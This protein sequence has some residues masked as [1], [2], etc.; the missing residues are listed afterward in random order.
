MSKAIVSFSGGQDST[1]CLFWALENFDEVE[2]IGFYY[3]QRHS[4]ELACRK[5]IL[6]SLPKKF[7]KYAGKLGNDQLVDI[8]A[9]GKLADSALTK[10]G[11]IEMGD[12]GLPTS[13]VPAR[14]LI[15]LCMASSKAYSIG[16][17]TIVTGVCETDYSG[18]PDCREST[19]ISLEKA[20]SLGLDKQ[21]AI[22]TPL[23]HL[24]KA[25]TWKMAEDIGG[26]E[27]VNFIAKETH[28]CYEGDHVSEHDWGYGCGQCPAC[29]LREKGWK[30]YRG[31][32]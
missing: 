25:E 18:Y 4:V 28:T 19:I 6:K 29:V 8:S 20:I 5:E 32:K 13:F 10:D 3:G 7:P 15:F 14:N 16:A 9:F 12:N 17:D 23:M 22:I 24:T 26:E 11:D 21:I 30:E 2:T 1:T 27:M 31:M